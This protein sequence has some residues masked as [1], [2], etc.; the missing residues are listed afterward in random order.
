M[1]RL[2]LYL[3]TSVL[4]FAVGGAEPHHVA[5]TQTM[6][7]QLQTGVFAA[8]VSA[9]VVQE[10]T[11]APEPRRSDLIRLVED[12]KLGVLELDAAAEALA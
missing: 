12:H 6:L 1:R 3:D 9:V 2:R 11:A 8:Y 5:A 4:N 10:I 7:R